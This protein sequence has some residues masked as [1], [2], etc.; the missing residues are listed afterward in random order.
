V[1]ASPSEQETFGLA[2]VEAL[3]SGLPVYYTTCPPLENQPTP[4]A[5]RVPA[6]PAQF[7]AALSDA[8]STLDTP[9]KP[10]RQYPV[11]QAVTTHDIRQQA[12]TL[13]NLYTDLMQPTHD[14]PQPVTGDRR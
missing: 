14:E 8:L 1:F 9:T 4:Q 10:S 6:D 3:A 7:R 5:T 13:S 12:E 11:C 2:I